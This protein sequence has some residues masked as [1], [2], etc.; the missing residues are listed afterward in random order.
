MRKNLIIYETNYGTSKKVAKIFSLIL[1]ASKVF[2]IN[3]N[4]NNINVYDN[5]VFIF[6]FHG[7]TTAEKINK[8]IADN[9]EELL[10]KRIAIIGVGISKQDLNRYSD[11]LTTTLQK[12]VDFKE[13]IE[14]ELRLNK[15]TDEDKKELEGF[16]AKVGMPFIDMGKFKPEQAY[17][18][19]EK[20]TEVINSAEK[21][22]DDKV[23]MEEI[24][25]FILSHNTCALATGVN[26]FIRCTPIEFAYF[27]DKFYFITEG[28]LKFKGILQNPKVCIGIFDNYNGMD[29]IKG[30][31][32]TGTAELVD[33]DTYE[34][35]EVMK[36]KGIQLKVLD[37]I[38]INLNIV[39]VKVDKYEF[40]NSYFKK[41][42][43]DSKQVLIK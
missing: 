24:K 4:P 43:F 16:L 15:L 6:G 37:N 39:R 13:F 33:N 21:V 38:P 10:K 14:G 18:V 7:Y 42:G 36:L 26:D 1:G 12:D 17:E 30:L 28:G 34:Y 23:L 35:E 2:N 3:D 27:N 20:C 8:Y 29:K 5:V 32:V 19:A 25:K 22:V 41:I 9:R 11:V 31:Q 40:L